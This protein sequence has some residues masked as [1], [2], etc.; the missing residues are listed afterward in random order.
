MVLSLL[1]S[2]M[3]SVP[4]Q[5]NSGFIP[6]NGLSAVKFPVSLWLEQGAY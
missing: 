5:R 4:Q 3:V 1:T 2:V 6:E